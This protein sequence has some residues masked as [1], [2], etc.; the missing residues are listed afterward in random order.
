MRSDGMLARVLVGT[1]IQRLQL[2]W[3]KA[4]LLR[5]VLSGLQLRLFH[6]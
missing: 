2:Q 3:S 1:L 4:F 5:H 6:K